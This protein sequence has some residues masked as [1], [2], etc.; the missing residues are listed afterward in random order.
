M[1]FII[2]NVLNS[3]RSDSISFCEL[4]FLWASSVNIF[5]LAKMA[6]EVQKPP[7]KMDFLLACG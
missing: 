4:V 2:A 3:A 5:S 6:S 7:A 1:I